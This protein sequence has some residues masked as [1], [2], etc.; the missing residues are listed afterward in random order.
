MGLLTFGRPHPSPNCGGSP[1]ECVGHLN[2][3]LLNQERWG[4]TPRHY[5]QLLDNWLLLTCSKS[6]L[7]H[8]S[9]NRLFSCEEPQKGALHLKTGN[10]GLPD[11]LALPGGN[12]MEE[13]ENSENLSSFKEENRLFLYITNRLQVA[14]SRSVLIWWMALR[15]E[16][17]D[18]PHTGK[19]GVM[20][21]LRKMLKMNRGK[22]S[23]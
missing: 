19:W 22:V 18:G 11:Q 10:L 8:A 1:D 16:L 23:W 17:S 3:T 14:K 2:S 15:T 9:L 6:Y 5:I 13:G 20:I 21:G 7:S 12:W 4:A